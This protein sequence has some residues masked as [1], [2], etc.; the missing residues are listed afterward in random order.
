MKKI[1]NILN[2][3]EELVFNNLPNKSYNVDGKLLWES[4]S[5]AVAGVVFAWKIG[6]DYPHV[7]VSKRGVN[8][9]DFQGKMN[10]TCGYIDFSETATE[11]MIRETWEETGLNLKSILESK[12]VDKIEHMNQPWN[13]NSSPYANRQNI[14][15]RF[16]LCFAIDKDDDFPLLSVD[17][18]EVVGEVEDPKWIKFDEINN[19]EWAFGH[20]KVIEEYLELIINMN[21]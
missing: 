16:G 5:V 1:Q 15:L 8:S 12:D 20:D 17:N 21:H 10:L 2:N 6:D 18:N 14:T 19:Y 3:S 13:V 9:A 7:L 11:A 4:R